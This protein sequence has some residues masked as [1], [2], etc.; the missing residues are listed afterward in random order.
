MVQVVPTGRRSDLIDGWAM[1]APGQTDPR[2]G[3]GTA[4]GPVSQMAKTYTPPGTGAME[5]QASSR[6][7]SMRCSMWVVR[8]TGRQRRC[9][10]GPRYPANGPVRAGLAG[11]PESCWNQRDGYDVN[12][13]A[14]FKHARHPQSWVICWRCSMARAMGRVRL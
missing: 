6:R 14:V 3:A 4:R 13:A 11:S 1:S 5:A 10:H 9:T 8:F 7:I 12:T 2:G